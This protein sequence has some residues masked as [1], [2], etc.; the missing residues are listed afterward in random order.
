[1]SLTRRAFLRIALASGSV[2]VLS[3]AFIPRGSAADSKELVVFA[4]ASLREVFQKLADSF[5]KSHPGVKVHLNFAGSQELRVQIEHGA[6]A[7]VFASADT[8]HMQA[9]REQKLAMEPARFARNEPVVIVPTANPAKLAR[10]VDL[11]KAE[12]IVVGVP[13]VPIGAYTETILSNSEQPYGAKFRRAVVEHIRSRELNVRQVLTKVSL[14]EADAGI[15]YKTDALS[16]KGK[17]T[18][19]EIPDTVNVIA[20]YPI[21]LLASA[22]QPT[23]AK[24]WLG[25]VLG[26][27][28]QQA[29]KAA[30]FRSAGD[31]VSPAAKR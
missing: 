20:D 21:A 7:D 24:E 1:M 3:T 26:P 10:F 6:K 27:E 11:P 15:V 2:A 4:A 12:R 22:P 29:L 25:T 23:L 5:E 17:V 28:G 13:E 8:K 14:G 16:A 9:L 30:G 18:A 31:S 19:I